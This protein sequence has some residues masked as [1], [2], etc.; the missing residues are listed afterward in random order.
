MNNPNLQHFLTKLF[1]YYPLTLAGTIL[2]FFCAWLLGTGFSYQNPYNILLSITALTILLVFSVMG[3]IRAVHFNYEEVQWDSGTPLYAEKEGQFHRVV[4]ENLRAPLFYRI[5]FLVKGR[6][7]VGNGAYCYIFREASSPGEE[8]LHLPLDFTFS[9]RAQVKGI[10]SLRDIFGLTRTRFGPVFKRTL[11]V[12]PAPFSFHEKFAISALGGQE[13][14]TTRKSSE[15]ERYYM[16]E[17]IPGDRFRDINW[18]SSSRLSQLITRISPHSQ[19]KTK[20][21]N[22][23]FRHFWLPHRESR[24]SVAHL[25]LLKSVLV[26]FLRKIKKEHTGYNFMIKTARGSFVLETDEDINRFSQELSGIFFEAEDTANAFFTGRADSG[27]PSLR[28]ESLSGYGIPPGTFSGRAEEDIYIFST[29]YDS[30]L[31]LIMDFYRDSQIYLFITTRKEE[32]SEF[33]GTDI[34]G[35]KKDLS[36]GKNIETTPGLLNIHST[37]K[38]NKKHSAKTFFPLKSISAFPIPGVWALR[39][40]RILKKPQVYA[41][42]NIKVL[43]FPLNTKLFP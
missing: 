2:V 13:E 39:G 6:M 19:E 17:Y 38:N 41:K 14:K 25:N 4:L 43:E 30:N 22:V 21:I 20:L 27:I 35:I 34:R 16:R 18:K 40:D 10:L 26:S 31:P 15:E 28:S 11:L 23:E 3:R 5:H 33:Y 37:E 12:Q 29:P 32:K 7:I 8:I 42:T 24:D 36:K 9:G 1:F